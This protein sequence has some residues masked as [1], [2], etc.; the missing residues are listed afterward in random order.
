M[1]RL[2]IDIETRSD[3]DIK[4]GVYKYV[5]SPAFRILLIAYKFSDED[6]VHVADLTEDTVTAFP[7]E[8][9]KALYD[10]TI[11][12]TAYNANFEITCFD[13]YFKT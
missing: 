11:L 5:D 3:I 10:E 6:T 8:L 9:F 13:Q 4:N 7:Y 12:K 2:S 1:R